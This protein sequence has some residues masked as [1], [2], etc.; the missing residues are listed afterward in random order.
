MP[1]RTQRE[2][3]DEETGQP[4]VPA[5]PSLQ[6]FDKSNAPKDEE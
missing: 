2:K 4:F 3:G 5:S 1:C 6:T